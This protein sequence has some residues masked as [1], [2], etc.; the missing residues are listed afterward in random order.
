MSD[1]VLRTENLTVRFGGLL[2]VH[3]VS[4]DCARGQLTGLIGPNGCLLYTSD[5]ADE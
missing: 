1:A 2:A 5:A 4:L 3:D